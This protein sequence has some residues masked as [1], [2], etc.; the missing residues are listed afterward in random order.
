M[1]KMS[2][3]MVIT[4]LTIQPLVGALTTE[5]ANEIARLGFSK[6]ENEITANPNVVNAQ[7]DTPLLYVARGLTDNTHNLEIVNDLLASGA[8]INYTN[9]NDK[10]TPLLAAL[11]AKSSELGSN[12]PVGKQNRI[13][14]FGVAKTLISQGADINAVAI[15]GMTPLM[16][17]AWYGDF[18]TVKMLLDN[19]ANAQAKDS[20]GASATYFAKISKNK[21]KQAQILDLLEKA[22][23]KSK[24]G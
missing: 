14:N 3:L 2:F 18:D 16:L 4:I 13:P 10:V 6:T 20:R 23:S 9:P 5:N 1:K 11:S 15:N 19:G 21:E 8:T 17:A 22:A 7:G 24:L 12:L